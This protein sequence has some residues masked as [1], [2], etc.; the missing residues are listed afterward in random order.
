MKYRPQG[1][2]AE[3]MWCK[4]GL[5]GQDSLKNVLSR[6]EIEWSVCEK[7]NLDQKFGLEKKLEQFSEKK[8][9]DP[10]KFDQN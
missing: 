4:I 2:I 6:Q 5:D 9:V 3:T 8:K 10:P 1:G 7:K